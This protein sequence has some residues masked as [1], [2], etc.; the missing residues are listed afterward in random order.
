MQRPVGDSSASVEPALEG[1]PRDTTNRDILEIEDPHELRRMLAQER[2]RNLSLTETVKQLKKHTVE[3]SIKVEEEEEL[4]AN[5]LIQRLTRLRQEKEMLINKV[6]EEEEMISNKLQKKLLEVQKEKQDMERELECE[7]EYIVNRLGQQLEAAK[8]ENRR[9]QE[10]IAQQ[11]QQT[12]MLASRL[13]QELSGATSRRL[14]LELQRLRREK[15]EINSSKE[16]ETELLFNALTSDVSQM[17]MQSRALELRQVNSSLDRLKRLEKC[18]AAWLLKA[19]GLTSVGGWPASSGSPAGAGHP[20]GKPLTFRSVEKLPAV[21]ESPRAGISVPLTPLRDDSEEE[22]DSEDENE[23]GEATEREEENLLADLI[24]EERGEG[25]DEMKGRVEAE[26]EG[27]GGTQGQ[28]GGTVG[29]AE[30]PHLT[31]SELSPSSAA[32]GV[33]P[34]GLVSPQLAPPQSGERGEGESGLPARGLSLSQ[35]FDECDGPREGVGEGEVGGNRVSPLAAQRGGGQASVLGGSGQGGSVV[36]RHAMA[37]RGFSAPSPSFSVQSSPALLTHRPTGSFLIDAPPSP[38]PFSSSGYLGG[39]PSQRQWRSRFSKRKARSL[40]KL[41]ARAFAR[42]RPGEFDADEFG[43]KLRTGWGGASSGPGGGVD[44]EEEREKERAAQLLVKDTEGREKLL[45]KAEHQNK[46]LAT[47]AREML[48]LVLADRDRL[49]RT[50]EGLLVS[51]SS[52]PR[53]DRGDKIEKGE[54]QKGDSRGRSLSAPGQQG[55]PFASRAHSLPLPLPPLLSF[56]S[57][58]STA[59]SVSSASAGGGGG[60]ASSSVFPL[61]PPVRPRPS[62]TRGDRPARGVIPCHGPGAASPMAAVMPPSVISVN[63]HPSRGGGVCTPSLA[64]THSVAH[65]LA[66]SFTGISTLGGGAG[67]GPVSGGGGGRSSASGRTGGGRPSLRVLQLSMRG[68]GSAASTGFVSDTESS[69]STP[70]S[71]PSLRGARRPHVSK[72]IYPMREELDPPLEEEEGEGEGE[73]E[74]AGGGM[75]TEGGRQE[76]S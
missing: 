59:G 65:S 66:S 27:E 49:M 9:L 53:R 34:G 61:T 30:F 72:E 22:A 57:N 28:P 11:K 69:C 68:P 64:P 46:D 2:S 40:A 4:I 6:E 3:L 38:F 1:Q 17:A 24:E 63:D 21:E 37:S 5:R 71:L 75:V 26:R 76:E 51:P 41:H 31:Y 36:Q 74:G 52:S 32:G 67:A 70:K 62:Q 55:P 73:A 7:Q 8:N 39:P 13:Q 42:L 35:S 33:P 12:E 60:G 10:K 58:R 20:V 54:K 29:L 25:G 15:F 14:Q 43:L 56:H 19:A 45:I 48:E 44:F 47:F 23:L 50:K 18:L 16:Q